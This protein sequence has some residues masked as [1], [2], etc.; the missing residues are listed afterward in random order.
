[1]AELLKLR[2]LKRITVKEAHVWASEVPEKPQRVTQ[3][4]DRIQ[5]LLTPVV[6]QPKEAETVT[7]NVQSIQELITGGVSRSNRPALPNPTAVNDDT[8]IMLA[9]EDFPRNE[10]EF[11]HLFSLRPHALYNHVKHTFQR[12]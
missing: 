2:G 8:D 4:L 7:T 10:S 12:F 5:I 9:V 3:L 6:T 1:M 11:A